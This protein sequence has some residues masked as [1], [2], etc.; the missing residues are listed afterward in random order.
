MEDDYL[1]DYGF[2]DEQNEVLLPEKGKTFQ[3]IN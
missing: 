1:P 3:G 2:E